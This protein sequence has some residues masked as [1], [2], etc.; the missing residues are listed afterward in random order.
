MIGRIKGIKHDTKKELENL[1]KT[2]KSNSRNLSVF[3]VL[4]SLLGIFLGTYL[5]NIP[6]CD[7]ENL[8]FSNCNWFW[9]L[10][11]I[12]L[13]VLFIFLSYWLFNNSNSDKIEFLDRIIHREELES[14]KTLNQI[15][16]QGLATLNEETCTTITCEDPCE[17]AEFKSRLSSILLPLK[18]FLA[19]QLKASISLG[20]YLDGFLTLDNE[21]KITEKNKKIIPLYDDIGINKSI[22]DDLMNGELR[23]KQGFEKYLFYNITHIT[24][25]E[26]E[27]LKLD[28]N[29]DERARPQEIYN[30]YVSIFSLIPDLCLEKKPECKG[31]LYIITDQDNMI[32]GDFEAFFQLY[33]WIIGNYIDQYNQCVISKGK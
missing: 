7:I 11:T 32:V 8:D 26:V 14:Q 31:G 4:N 28:I 17:P 30:P 22:N 16:L 21:G 2:I 9:I 27:T 23:D 18:D 15:L 19:V 12:F 3:I 24:Y 6:T 29:S 10:F 33:G 25:D 5:D 13:I 20:I 1:R